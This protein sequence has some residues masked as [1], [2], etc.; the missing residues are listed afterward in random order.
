MGVLM[1]QASF[2]ALAAALAAAPAYAQTV[3]DDTAQEEG[4][5]RVELAPVEVIET[6]APQPAYTGFDAVD[7]GLSIVGEQA[8]ENHESG[9][10][11]LMDVL[12]LAPF[13]RHGVNHFS[14]D[15]EDLQDLRPSDIS[16]SGGQ[17]YDNL[18]MLDGVSVS[19]VHDVT[20]N[21][22]F[23]YNE[24]SGAGAQSVFLDP[25]LIGALEL[26]DSNVSARYGDFSGG[27]VNAVVRNPSDTFGASLRIGYES[28]DLVDYIYVD[29]L[30]VDDSNPPPTFTKWR[31]HGTV[32]LPIN[33]Q[34]SVLLGFGRTV[35]EVDYQLNESYGGNFRGHSSTSD[36]FLIKSVYEFSDTL[37]LTGSVIYSPYESE[38]ANQNGI[39]NLIVSQGGGLTGKLE[40]DGETGETI[41]N[42]KASYAYS[43]MSRTAPPNN[44]SWSSDAPSIDFCSSTNC[45][46]GGFGDLDQDQREYTLEASL[47][48]PF[49]GGEFSAGA[50][51][52]RTEAYKARLQDNY[53]YSRGEYDPDTV[54]LDADD[55]A[56][57]DGE[58]ALPVRFDYKA[59]E[60]NVEINQASAWV[61]HFQSF[62]P[63]DIR[64]GLRASRNDY[65]ENTEIA[66]RLSAVWSITPDWQLTVGGNRYYAGDFVGYDIRSQYPD[67]Y[68]YER[69]GVISRSDLVY[70]S[71][72]WVLT[73]VS[74]LTQYRPSTLD[75]PYSDEFTA[76]LTFPLLNGVGR[77]KG[78]QRWHRDQLVRS[79]SERLEETQDGDTFL[80]TVYFPTNEGAKDYVGISAEWVGSWRNHTLS[81][82]VHWED[83]TSRSANAGG[84]FDILDPE[85]LATDFI[86]YNG[87]IISMAELETIRIQEDYAT[88]LEAN[89]S[90]QSSWL[91]DTLSTTL[92]LYYRGEYEIIDDTGVNE[93]VDGVR[94]DLFDTVT[95]D[96]SLWT[97]FNVTYSLP[98]TDFGQ[99]D[100]QVRVSNLFNDLPNTDYSSTNPYQQGR[101]IWFGLN[102]RI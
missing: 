8:I 50:Q 69:E 1:K 93:V 64:A 82:N 9:S 66:P 74:H 10:G 76:A 22:P 36:Q 23:N 28:D 48:R 56:C 16:I 14:V 13:V 80:R 95:R 3:E 39:D 46:V 12:R 47:T 84:Y 101:S 29:G 44:F 27:V 24:V 92:W 43:D 85:G 62:G 59:Y 60:A 49:L 15:Q 7:S 6:P 81:T 86:L 88:P 40:L 20:E 45:T 77:L 75:T 37:Q 89:I 65:L 98:E 41:W 54:C 97:N 72:D 5:T 96:A 70:S 18:F 35:S 55:P 17:I 63:V 83:L 67:L 90:L 19:N 87:E 4:Q 38:A 33:E 58:I 25:S 34:M 68:R 100:L 32:D 99:V 71:D 21:N 94:Y 30:D 31:A 52:S 42:I 2:F 79:P 51:L 78:V 26:R 11:D 91:S 53:A 61:E 57:I 73:R 102:Y